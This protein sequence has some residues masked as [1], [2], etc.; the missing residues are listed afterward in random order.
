MTFSFNNFTYTI[1]YNNCV[2]VCTNN[3]NQVESIDLP[4]D[5]F[6]V[7]E[8]DSPDVAREIITDFLL[9][10]EESERETLGK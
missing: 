8:T 3:K 9:E 4:F 1:D 7:E 6:G 10:Q 2:V 5:H